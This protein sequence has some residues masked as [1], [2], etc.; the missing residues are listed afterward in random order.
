[1]IDDEDSFLG[2]LSAKLAACG[3]G[4]GTEEEIQK[5]TCPSRQVP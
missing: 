4:A 2:G 1:M 5:G 3:E